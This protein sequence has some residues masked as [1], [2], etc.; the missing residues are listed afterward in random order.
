MK[1]SW[2]WIFIVLILAACGSGNENEGNLD[3]S[4]TNFED[5]S[6]QAAGTTVDLHMWGGD[7][8]INQYI[9]EW[10]APKLEEEHNITLK[11]TPVD[12]KDILSKLYNEKLAN[13][14]DGTVDVIWLNGENFKNAKENELLYGPFT[15]HLPAYQSYYDTDSLSYNNDFGTS[16]DGLEAPWGK[17]QF[18]FLYDTEKV[19]SPPQ[20]FEE[21]K[22]WIHENPGK[23]TYPNPDDFSGNAFVRHLLYQAS[24]STE[25]LVQEPY[26]DEKADALGK[27]VW[28]YLKE[29]KSDL[30]RNGEHYPSSL[31]ELDRLYSQGDVWMTMGY[32][33]ARSEH[34]IDQGVFPESTKSFIMEPGSLGNTH[35]LAIPF[36]SGN[37]AGAITSINYLLSPEAQYVKLQPKYWGDNTPISTDNLPKEQREKFESLDR[38]ASVLPARELEDRFLPEVDSQ[39]VDWIKEN[40]QNEIFKTD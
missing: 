32:N 39:Y 17:V 10:V 20:S 7:E 37:K 38:G 11:R 16:V 29:I 36:N 23:F 25:S 24:D 18:T 28:T 21:L 26:S 31:T 15:D 1:K 35:F 33:E 2:V 4:E 12:T 13:K 22:Q 6:A 40:W 5:I 3:L 30:W 14:E 9:D 27:E 19:D 8:G 34:L